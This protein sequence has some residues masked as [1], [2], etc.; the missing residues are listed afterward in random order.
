MARAVTD[1]PSSGRVALVTG[2]GRDR[3]IGTA[4]QAHVI[5]ERG[6]DEIALELDTSEAVVRKR[7]SRGLAVARRRMWRQ[8]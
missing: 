6:Y 7:V 4:V 5:D 3:E 1:P 8:P 2:A